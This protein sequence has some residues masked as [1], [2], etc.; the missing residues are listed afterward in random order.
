MRQTEHFLFSPSETHAHLCFD[1]KTLH[2]DNCPGE[3]D[4]L[5]LPPSFLS[6]L[7]AIFHILEALLPSLLCISIMGIWSSQEEDREAPFCA[8]D[9]WVQL[10]QEEGF[11]LPMAS[12]RSLFSDNGIPY[13]HKPLI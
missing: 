6:G 5:R 8:F 2:T 3:P 12:A 11:F 4:A 7:S 13:Y 1:G 10:E 9:L